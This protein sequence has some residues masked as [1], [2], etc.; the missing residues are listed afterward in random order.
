VASRGER[1]EA[2][3]EKVQQAIA[4]LDN[5][6]AGFFTADGD[7]TIDYLNATLAQWLRLDLGDVAGGNLKLAKIMSEDGAALIARAGRGAAQGDTRRFDIDLVK[8]DGTTL[9]VR[10]LHCLPRYGGQ[11][12]VL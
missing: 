11:R 3:Y 2:G 6:P 8:A 1:K 4:Y 5:A 12:G 9:P 10:I 7:G